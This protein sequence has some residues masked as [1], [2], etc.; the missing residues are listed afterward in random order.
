MKDKTYRFTFFS[1]YQR[2]AI[3]EYLERMAARGWM[4]DKAGNA[5]WRF[6]KTEPRRLHMEVVFFPDASGFDPGP[7]PEL[8][9]MEEYCARDG[10][11]L[12]AQWGQAQL[13]MNEREDPVPIET[14]P[15]TQVEILH[16]AMK[17]TMLPASFLLLGIILLQIGMLA[18]QFRQDPIG[19]LSNGL[20]LGMVPFWLMLLASQLY[21]II[22][23]FLWL[24]RTRRA[25]EDGVFLSSG[26]PRRVTWVLLGISVVLLVCATLSSTSL[27]GY[28]V[29]GCVCYALTFLLVT[30]LR[31]AMKERG[32]SRWVNRTVS[33][34]LCFLLTIGFTAGVA[35]LLIGS[36]MGR[37]QAPETYRHNG[38]TFDIWRDDL[39][40]TLSDLADPGEVR[41][42][43][44]ARGEKSFLLTRTRY[45]QDPLLGQGP[46]VCRLDYTV[47]EVKA[48]F[49]YGL[50]RDALLEIDP[51][52]EEEYRPADPAPWGAVEAYQRYWDGMPREEYLLCFPRRLVEFKS[53]DLELTGE[54]MGIVG[55]KLGGG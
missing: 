51:I 23:Y 6:K 45:E 34:G 29:A 46:G 40:L 43:T 8:R 48:P 44:R 13:F 47:V 50:C 9:T 1:L 36:G 53:Y 17:R 52:F 27:M 35:A 33:I 19:F 3:A 28:I 30:R 10:W 20:Q 38:I 25:A 42:S 18:V 7:T 31:D 21:E 22:S 55:A 41:Y 2:E 4:L 32:V 49:L 16:K 11:T 26:S 15:V 37:R 5:V 24:R 14:D 39:P 12:L 54:R